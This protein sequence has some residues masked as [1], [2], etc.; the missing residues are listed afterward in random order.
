M[1]IKK[2]LTP[3]KRRRVF[4]E[5]KDFNKQC[6]DEPSTKASLVSRTVTDLYTEDLPPFKLLPLPLP[7]QIK[8]GP[9]PDYSYVFKNPDRVNM[10]VRFANIYDQYKQVGKIQKREKE[11]LENKRKAKQLEK[12]ER[13]ELLALIY[14][15][16]DQAPAW[17]KRLT[18]ANFEG[19]CSQ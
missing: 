4:F 19:Y 16:L 10:R 15:T 5:I 1:I 2:L 7:K 3:Q 12:R 13:Q 8:P 17:I 14:R 11:K 18:F 9:K 6:Y